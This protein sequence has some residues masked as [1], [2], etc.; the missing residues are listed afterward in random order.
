[1]Q[2]EGMWWLGKVAV[3][4]LGNGGRLVRI[5]CGQ[6]DISPSVYGVC[7]LKS[8][9][10]KLY[11][12]W[13]PAYINMFIISSASSPGSEMSG[14]QQRLSS[15]F[16][17]S[18]SPV[19]RTPTLLLFALLALIFRIR[20]FKRSSR[21]SG[22]CIRLGRGTTVLPNFSYRNTLRQ[23]SFTLPSL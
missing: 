22:I 11:C 19:C 10:H 21:L 15:P 8:R 9:P 4:Y 3:A 23:T 2:R 17:I 13:L 20:I 16:R 12:P 1:M 7:L 18:C 5:N 6:I 14:K